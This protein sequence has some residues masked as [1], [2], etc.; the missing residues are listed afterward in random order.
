MVVALKIAAKETP[1]KDDT[2]A[3]TTAKQGPWVF[4]TCQF[5]K[6]PLLVYGLVVDRS[7]D[8]VHSHNAPPW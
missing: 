6:P 5:A 1:P 3:F 2:T 7:T 8:V 4:S